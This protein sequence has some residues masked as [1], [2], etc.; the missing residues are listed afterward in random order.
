MFYILKWQRLGQAIP[1][2]QLDKAFDTV[3]LVA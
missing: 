3:S 1:Q 2:A